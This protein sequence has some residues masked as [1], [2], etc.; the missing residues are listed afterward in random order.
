M[1][2]VKTIRLTGFLTRRW[3][4]E[5]EGRPFRR[6]VRKQAEELASDG[7]SVE[8]IDGDGDR[9]DYLCG[10]DEQRELLR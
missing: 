5:I 7:A 3:A 10:V 4:E 8:V 1:P 9:I 2:A 6:Q